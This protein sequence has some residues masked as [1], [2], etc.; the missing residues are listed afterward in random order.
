MNVALSPIEEAEN[1]GPRVTCVLADGDSGISVR[2]RISSRVDSNLGSRSSGR[3]GRRP[4]RT[5]GD[6][7]GTSS[8]VWDESGSADG[9]RLELSGSSRYNRING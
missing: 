1:G 3:S 8:S 9:L 7:V 6:L 5:V 4:S 2:R